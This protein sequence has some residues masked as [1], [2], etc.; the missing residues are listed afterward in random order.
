[1]EEVAEDASW[2]WLL[3]LLAVLVVAFLYWRRKEGVKKK[4]K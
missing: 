1:V 4:R 3:V 2:L